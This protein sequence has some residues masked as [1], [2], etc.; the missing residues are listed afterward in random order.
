[1]KTHPR[2]TLIALGASLWLLASC[3]S[4]GAAPAWHTLFDGQS[5]DGW[6]S[7]NY[8]GEGEVALSNDG[9]VL[10][11]GAALTGIRYPAGLPLTTDYELEVR[12][13]R[14]MGT[15]FFC[16]L[17]IPVGEE[18]AT[19]ILGGWGGGLCGLSCI[20]G[21]DASMNETKSLRSFERGV[22]HSLIVRVEARR[23]RAWVNRV[24]LFDVDTRGRRLSLR[25]EVLP[26]APLGVSAYVTTAEVGSVRWRPL[27]E[28]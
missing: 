8:G 5:L 28:D 1:M 16:G 26:S 21:N 15:D 24:L 7:I 14:V 12:A 23:V 13:K 3:A 2:R 20:D 17:T 22:E 11:R 10:P 27:K 9:V 6:E 18:F 25:A 4:T 19:V